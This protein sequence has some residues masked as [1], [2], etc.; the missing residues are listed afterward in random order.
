[1]AWSVVTPVL[2]PGGKHTQA[3][4]SSSAS[5]KSRQPRTY[6]AQVWGTQNILCR[7]WSIFS[8]PQDTKDYF[9]KNKKNSP[10]SSTRKKEKTKCACPPC[11]CES[12]PK[13]S[14]SQNKSWKMSSSSSFEAVA[15]GCNKACGCKKNFCVLQPPPKKKHGTE[16]NTN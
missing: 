11:S 14:N 6:L 5:T 8:L 12:H 15:C 2:R 13:Q 10:S 3:R 16:Q 1:M 9:A 7:V 4:L